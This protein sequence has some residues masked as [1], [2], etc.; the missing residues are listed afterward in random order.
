M[1]N[2]VKNIDDKK[3]IIQELVTKGYTNAQ[4]ID[5]LLVHSNKIISLSL[6]KNRLKLWGISRKQVVNDEIVKATIVQEC[7]GINRD[8]GYRAMQH[9]L[10]MK[11]NL[12]V[13]R[14]KV[15]KMQHEVDSIGLE[16]RK[17]QKLVRRT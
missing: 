8:A 16:R 10:R 17:K 4:I 6:L 1:P 7:T 5:Y 9:I 2:P 14:D 12:H 11:Y 15:L 3:E 13:P